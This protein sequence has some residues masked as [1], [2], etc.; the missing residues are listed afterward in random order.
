MVTRL[1]RRFMQSLSL[2]KV[3]ALGGLGMRRWAVQSRGGMLK[4]TRGLR[5]GQ[6][7]ALHPSLSTAAGTCVFPWGMSSPICLSLHPVHSRCSVNVLEHTHG[8][9]LMAALGPQ[10]WAR[11]GSGGWE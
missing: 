3:R 4:S 1:Q 2:R 5:G 10:G 7:G 8:P 9:G 11:L 6:E